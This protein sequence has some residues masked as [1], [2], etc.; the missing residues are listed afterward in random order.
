MLLL[1]RISPHLFLPAAVVA[2]STFNIYLR[3]SIR[4]AEMGGS[5]FHLST[6]SSA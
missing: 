3:L 4:V 1:L 5:F 2:D 6:N